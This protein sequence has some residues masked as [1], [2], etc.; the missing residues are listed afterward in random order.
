MWRLLQALLIGRRSAGSLR[1]GPFVAAIFLLSA[2]RKTL[3][4]PA[5]G[6]RRF[7]GDS[8]CRRFLEW[9]VEDKRALMRYWLIP[10]QDEPEH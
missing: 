2:R 1:N 9:R 5:G 10:M 8:A 6:G 3:K 4:R 7:S